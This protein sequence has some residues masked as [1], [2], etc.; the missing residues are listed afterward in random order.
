VIPKICGSCGVAGTDKLSSVY[1][2]WLQAD[3]RRVAY[4]QKL[5]FGC[6]CEQLLPLISAAMEPVLICPACGIETVDDHDDV[7]VTYCVP[8]QAKAQSEWP[9]C[10][11]CAVVVRNKA[12]V[13]AERLDD[14]ESQGLGANIGPQTISSEGTWAS[15]GLAPR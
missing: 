11:P 3:H 2:A 10:G 5:C 1:W 12:L 15:L 8:G 9:L 7:Y 13:G 14:R 6:F 4:K